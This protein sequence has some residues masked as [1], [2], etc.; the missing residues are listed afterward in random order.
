MP[1]MRRTVKDSVFT[2]LF[3]QPEYTRQL[4]LSLHP[5]D[6]DVTEQECKL[7]TM[8][9]I[10]STGLYNDIGI[11][12]RNKLLLLVEAQST[13]SEN[14]VLRMLLYLAATYKEYIE[15]HK[16]D[17]YASKAV[18]I[19]RPELYVVYTGE[20][21][22]IPDTLLLSDLYE[23]TGSV[24]VQV[25][26]LRDDSSGD[27]LAQY[28]RFC[29]IADNQRRL[30]GATQ[31]A[32]DETIRICMEEDVLTPFLASR[33]KEVLEIMVTLFDQEKIWEIHDYNV[34]QAARQ[35]GLEQGRELG[36]EQ[37]HKEGLEEGIEQGREQ[38]IRSMVSALEELSVS[39]EAIA[40]KLASKFDLPLHVAEE[41]VQQYSTR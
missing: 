21:K 37:G 30:H 14:I 27:I 24:E 17:L 3:K 12:V 32:I 29:K 35:E 26:V 10:L 38:G 33:K 39:K 40:Q 15:E 2:Y 9:N 1:D 41:K 36:L 4:Y 25:K 5:E 31:E 20:R 8:E 22:N 11:Q 28:V 23:G 34:A 13:F 6:V 7:V 16:L 18:S 19:P